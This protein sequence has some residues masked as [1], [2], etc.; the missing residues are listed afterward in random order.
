[1]SLRIALTC[2]IFGCGSFCEI[3]APA[4][5]RETELTTFARQT[6]ADRY[7]WLTTVYG[8]YCRPCRTTPKET[9]GR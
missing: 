7:G 5:C 3:T 4:T 9:T 8:D 2:D 6:A 1:M